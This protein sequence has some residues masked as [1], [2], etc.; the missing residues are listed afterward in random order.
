[1]THY[2]LINPFI[3]FHVGLT[4]DV[5]RLLSTPCV[6]LSTPVNQIAE[7]LASGKAEPPLVWFSYEVLSGAGPRFADLLRFGAL[8]VQEHLETFLDRRDA[9]VEV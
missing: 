6:Q 5:G 3:A 4:L 1:M 7:L 8:E 9:A 2:F